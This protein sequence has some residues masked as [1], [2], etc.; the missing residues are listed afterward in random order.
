M[1]RSSICWPIVLSLLAGLPS[2]AAGRDK[3]LSS[4][5]LVN[6]FLAPG[7][8]QWLVGPIARLASEEEVEAYLAITDDEI[9]ERF[10]DD[11][12]ARREPVPATPGLTARQQ[13]EQLAEDADLLFS[14]ATRPGRRTDRGTIFILYGPADEVDHTPVRPA[15][16][17]RYRAPPMSSGYGQ[18]E[19][20]RYL[21][22]KVGLDG[23]SPK[24]VY[25]FIRDS[26]RTRFAPSSQLP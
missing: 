24:P 12:W 25:H 14:E 11:F 8:A 4:D 13:F 7:N 17:G 18:V 1:K 2:A 3:R 19:R 26:D 6:V 5:E 10:I 20:W 16:S 21:K 15:Q 23:R 22:K 9:A